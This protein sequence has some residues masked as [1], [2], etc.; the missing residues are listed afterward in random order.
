MQ[1]NGTI[2]RYDY[3]LEFKAKPAAAPVYS[4]KLEPDPRMDRLQLS[5]DAVKLNKDDVIK[6]PDAD[7]TVSDSVKQLKQLYIKAYGKDHISPCWDLF[8]KRESE[9]SLMAPFVAAGS[10][11]VRQMV[12]EAAEDLTGYYA[13]CGVMGS[14]EVA[15][16]A[17]SVV[18]WF[19][20][21]KATKA[22]YEKMKESLYSLFDE[23]A[24][25]VRKGEDSSVESLTTKIEINGEQLS[26]SELMKIQDR[27][28]ALLNLVNGAVGCTTDAVE[29]F[30]QAGAIRS[31]AASY[32]KQ[33]PEG[34]G[35]LYEEAF[36]RM[37]DRFIAV[38]GEA[39]RGNRTEMHDYYRRLA[40]AGDEVYEKVSH[41]DYDSGDLETEIQKMQKDFEKA[42]A[43]HRVRPFGFQDRMDEVADCMRKAFDIIHS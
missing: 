22:D 19:Y 43:R 20:G 15:E 25:R 32:A 42:A 2:K 38:K 1:I 30:A 6:P 26:L 33:M 21:E 18:N 27:T 37:T 24:D 8:R 31:A 36:S 14:H 39:Q 11:F 5:K 41:A 10:D 7:W 3:P 17:K 28:N 13:E 35:R 29:R 12:K 9:G 16:Y 4:D 23:A 34:V 40:N